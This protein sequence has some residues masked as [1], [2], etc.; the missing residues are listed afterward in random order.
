LVDSRC[1]LGEC[2]LWDERRTALFW[3]DITAQRLWMHEPAS[4][5]TRRWSLP[6]RLGCLALC[7]DGRLLLGLAK[8][9]ALADIEP[10]LDA[11]D[12]AELPLTWLADVEP[13][14]ACTRIND[15]RCDRNGNFVF[16]TKDEGPDAPR[17]RFYQFSFAHGL[18]LLDLPPA[19]IPN[20]ICF[21]PD[22]GTL[23]FCDSVA[24]RIL[25]CRYDADRASVH[26][27]RE[28][29]RLSAEASPD[30]SIV[31]ADGRVWNAQWGAGRVVRYGVDGH[32]EG[33]VAVPV[34][35]PSCCAL[36]GPGFDVLYVST[37]REDMDAAELAAMPQAGG[38]YAAPVSGMRGLRESRMA[39]PL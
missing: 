32:I 7:D 24:P 37:A 1:E 15:G 22:G 5:K 31:D 35:N 18:R 13:G 38:L 20:S 25:C 16:G 28:F 29:A 39:I 26:D 2:V 21:S 14:S 10:W 19:A 27:V 4:A 17:G 34:R 8:G 3:T 36:G 6:Q 12:D 23:Y 33:T 11:V 9:L 30:G